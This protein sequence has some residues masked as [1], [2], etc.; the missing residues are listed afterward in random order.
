MSTATD[1]LAAYIA[2]ETAILGGQSYTINGHSFARADLQKVQ[3]GRAFWQVQV[4]KENSTVSGNKSYA[5]A[6]FT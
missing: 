5:L 2:A 6:D 4:D 3:E 1:M